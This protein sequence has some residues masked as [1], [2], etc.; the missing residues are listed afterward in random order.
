MDIIIHSSVYNLTSS[1][2]SIHCALQNI[3]DKG[4]NN[5]DLPPPIYTSIKYILLN[6]SITFNKYN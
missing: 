3:H 4:N 6:I 1:I 5:D 2:L